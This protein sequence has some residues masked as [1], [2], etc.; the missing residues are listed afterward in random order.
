MKTRSIKLLSLLLLICTLVASLAACGKPEDPT[1]ETPEFVDYVAQ[2]K[3][4]MS[5]STLKQTVT[6]KQH[7][8]GD[9]THFHVPASVSP[10]GVMKARYNG[11][12]TP[13]S[14]GDIEEW[15]K[16]ASDFTNSKI[17]TAAEILVE[18]ETD[19]WNYDGNGRFIVWV[20]YKPTAGADWRNLNL[21][22][23]QNGF[24]MGYGEEGIYGKTCVAAIAQATRLKLGKFS[25]PDPNYP[26]EAI[27]VDLKTLRVDPSKFVDKKVS[28]EGIV[29]YYGDNK[30]Y[31]EHYDAET[32]MYY[33]IQVFDGYKTALMEVLSPGNRVRIVG[34]VTVF[35]GTYQVSGLTYNRMRPNDPDNS[36]IISSG[37]ERSFRLTT[38]EQ[39]KTD[40]T[41]AIGED[42]AET[43]T[44]K[45][46]ELIVSTSI[47]M[48]NLKVVDTYTTSSGD[49]AGAFTLTCKAVN[50][51]GTL[52]NFEIDI[53]TNSPI[54][55]SNGETVL[56]SEYMGKI[57][58]VKGIVDYFDLNNTGNGSY[59]VKIFTTSDIT[60]K[61]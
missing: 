17:S 51:D 26:R 29:A 21:E 50:D 24:G 53:R 5:S 9:T 43:K 42:G 28:F 34:T 57:I 10:E 30:A 18:S 44:F 47:S 32:D 40:V 19:K 37:N 13:E 6:L 61:E 45:Y 59:Q 54:K 25:G 49:N 2:T 52:S 56:A 41:V 12:N 1:P 35:S 8:D 48:K 4:D 31:V 27:P 7:I 20:W 38:P 39:F 58:D 60:I 22:I 33:G 3:L 14:T 23:L 46:Q 36:A 16:A 11:V 15:G 55:K